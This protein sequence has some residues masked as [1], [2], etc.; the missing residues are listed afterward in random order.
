MITY[1]LHSVNG[2]Y[3]EITGDEGK[4]REYDV[5][6][7]D[8][9]EKKNIYETKMKVGSWAR[10]QRRYLSDIIVIVKY[11]DRPITQVNFLN[12]I[13]GKRVF[14]SFESKALGDTLAWMPYC[15]EFAKHYDC[16]VLVST[17]KNDLFESVYP[18][19]E[20][21]PRGVSVSNL[22][23]MFEIGWYWDKSKEP[24]NP[25]L[26]PLQKSATNIL[27][28]PYQELIPRINFTPKERPIEEKY[29]C[30]SIYSTAQV[31]L[32]Y[33][34]QG[35]IDHFVSKG[36]KVLEISAQDSMMY[37]NTADFKGL[38]PFTDKSLENTMNTIHHSE[39]FVGLSSGLSWLSWT[40]KKRVYMIAN[41]TKPDHEFNLNT[42]RITN[43]K[44]CNGCWNDPMFKFNKGDWNWCPVH[45]DTP[46]HFECHKSITLQTVIDIIEN[47]QATHK[48]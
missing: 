26:I 5:S 1:T 43:D 7:Y 27:H 41:F 33:E 36:Y 23:G 48:Q 24:E 21:V 46:R 42:V 17:F 2:L 34:W 31:K 30:I 12:H 22:V 35:L 25:I 47:D 4:N 37:Q 14:I 44:V 10:L 16:K 13:K 6:F 45:E 15:L 3:F 20:F 18:E 19:L 9:T 11:K 38:T 29:I 8:N 39:F 28:L 32:W 40:L